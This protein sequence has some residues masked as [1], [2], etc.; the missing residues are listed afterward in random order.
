MPDLKPP[1]R[2]ATAED[3]AELAEL[4]NFASDGLS[5][6]VWKGL[7][8]EGEDPWAVGHRR[9]AAK[10]AEGTIIVVD[11]GNGAVAG[12]I[13]YATGS[14]PEPIGEDV[15]GV[16]RPLI[17]LE[18]AAPDSWYVNAIACFPEVRGIGVGTSL[19]NLAEDF[20]RSAGLRRMSV[21]VANGNAGARRLYERKG[22]R[23]A[24]RRP[25][26]PGGWETSATEWVLLIKDLDK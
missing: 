11:Y 2:A 19:L 26:V 18:N 17:E 15:P 23:E 9:M 8:A 13:G 7:A 14:D 6:H 10:A 21:I 4:I 16:F 24:A 20:A 1:F 22:Y 5:M 12:L 3:A 25:C